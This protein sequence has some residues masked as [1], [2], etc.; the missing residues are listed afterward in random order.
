MNDLS[1]KPSPAI[2]LAVIALVF[3]IAGSAVAGTAGLSSKIT[4]SKVKKIADKRINA[5]APGL[6]VAKAAS[7]TSAASATNSDQLDGLGATAFVRKAETFTRSW[8]C[9][10]SA[11]ES[12]NSGSGYST[13]TG[14]K[15]GIG[16]F[17]CNVDL[18]S[19]AI[20]SQARFTVVDNDGGAGI[21]CEMW[22]TRMSAPIGDQQQMAATPSTVMT[23]GSVNLVDNT[24]AQNPID[25]ANFTYY[26]SCNSGGS[27]TGLYGATLTYQVS[28]G[29]G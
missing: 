4:K 25:N 20:V 8:G 27:N 12:V 26:L 24:I 1:S 28:G 13:S 3:A 16:I 5:L 29:D 23:P 21:S 17:A 9:A 7:A 11:W 14:L 2:V 22:R 10:G 18:P 15:N 19:G 6:S